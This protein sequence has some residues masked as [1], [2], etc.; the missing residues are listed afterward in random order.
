M[1]KQ[2]KRG[3]E[4]LCLPH[5]DRQALNCI[6]TAGKNAF[7]QLLCPVCLF[8]VV[9]VVSIVT[10][11]C[12]S[13]AGR[14]V[15][16]KWIVP[17]VLLPHGADPGEW[18]T[19]QSA[20]LVFLSTNPDLQ[21]RASAALVSGNVWWKYLPLSCYGTV[22]QLDPFA[23]RMAVMKTCIDACQKACLSKPRYRGRCGFPG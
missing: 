6:P 2:Q 14:S 3:L 13:P 7:H 5:P 18:S 1:T 17:E 23:E 11:V 12:P 19:F 21:G 10:S 4:L 16:A 15:S 20:G 9:G 8:P 22:T